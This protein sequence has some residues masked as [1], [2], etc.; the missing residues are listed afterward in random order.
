MAILPAQTELTRLLRAPR[1]FA[2]SYAAPLAGL[3]VGAAADLF[4]TYHNMRLYGPGI[5][6]HPAQRWVSELVG[7][8]A[9]VPV[10]KLVQLG[11]VLFVAAWWRGWTR[12]VLYLC[13]VLYAAAAVSNFFLLL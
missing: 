12:W 11:F 9:G 4:T 8:R 10:A 1:A 6:A 5:E 7:V 3:C 2:R 13:G